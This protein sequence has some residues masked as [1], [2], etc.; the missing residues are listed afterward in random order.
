LPATLRLGGN[1][2]WSVNRGP[3][4]SIGEVG[5]LRSVRKSTVFVLV[6]KDNERLVTL[7]TRRGDCLALPSC[8]RFCPRPGCAH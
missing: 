3:T 2:K 1:R 5:L 8:F 6:T 4:C 7:M